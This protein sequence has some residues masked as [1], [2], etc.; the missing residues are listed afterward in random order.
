MYRVLNDTVWSEV[1]V[2]NE[3]NGASSGPSAPKTKKLTAKLKEQMDKY[4]NAVKPTHDQFPDR[5]S[6]LRDY[7]LWNK[8][9]NPKSREYVGKATIDALGAQTGAAG[10]N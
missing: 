8:W 2:A 3:D 6:Y 7:G 1:H 10:G 4:L 9:N 5:A